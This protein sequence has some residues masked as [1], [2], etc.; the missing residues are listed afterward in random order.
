IMKISE[1]D[2]TQGVAKAILRNKEKDYKEA[3]R[4]QEN[5]TPE[6]Q[7]HQP[8]TEGGTAPLTTDILTSTAEKH[9]FLPS[10]YPCEEQEKKIIS[11]LMN[12]GDQTI[13]MPSKD[14][15]GNDIFEEFYVETLVV[16]D[17]LGDNIKFDN[18]LYQRIFD[19]F[20]EQLQQGKLLSGQHFVNHP[21]EI[22]RTLAASMLSQPYTISDEWYTK[23]SISVPMPDDK[24]VIAN[25]YHDSILNL[26]MKKLEQKITEAKEQLKDT[27]EPEEL[28][29]L[30]GQIKQ[31]ETIKMAIG[32]E[33]NRVIS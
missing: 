13:T 7:E 25:D 3:Q 20:A 9:Q 33:L 32:K 21:E 2:L 24:N 16:G 14:N 30:L 11:L 6:Q 27:T 29:I 12:Y 19:E 1:K 8:E 31:Y 5:T 4:A 10:F 26:K 17:I 23:Y 22:V 18:P 15:D 28:T